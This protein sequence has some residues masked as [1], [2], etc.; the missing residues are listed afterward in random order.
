MLDHNIS[1]RMVVMI[2]VWIN[3]TS[4]PANGRLLLVCLNDALSIADVNAW[5]FLIRDSDE[6]KS[7]DSW[8]DDGSCIS[9]LLYKTLE[10]GSV[11]VSHFLLDLGL[12]YRLL[13]L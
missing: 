2:A 6:K 13:L 1:H 5:V 3:R 10:S 9:L 12:G 7:D 8:D 11:Y 4:A